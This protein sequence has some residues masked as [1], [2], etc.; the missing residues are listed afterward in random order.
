MGTLDWT[1]MVIPSSVTGRRTP[2]RYHAQNGI[3]YFGRCC[4]YVWEKCSFLGGFCWFSGVA[5]S[6]LSGPLERSQ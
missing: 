1:T 6:C 2:V 4:D 5:R 3:F